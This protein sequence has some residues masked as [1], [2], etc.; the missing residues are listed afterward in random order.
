MD[1]EPAFALLCLVKQGTF[2]SSSW[3]NCK[4]PTLTGRAPCYPP[5]LYL[6]CFVSR[7]VLL[8]S[9]VSLLIWKVP[10]IAL[11]SE[12]QL[13]DNPV[14]FLPFLLSYPGCLLP[15]PTIFIVLFPLLFL[16]WKNLDRFSG[17]KKPSDSINVK[18]CFSAG[19][20]FFFLL[21]LAWN[22]VYWGKRGLQ[23]K[24]AIE[25]YRVRARYVRHGTAN[26]L[27]V[28]KTAGLVFQVHCTKSFL[29]TAHMD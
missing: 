29:T 23:S 3:R 13:I 28:T 2:A 17:K 4:L 20:F 14:G 10:R 16:V 1:W 18:T 27:L 5:P 24:S 22:K 25:V 11:A 15:F 6:F 7:D 19:S 9:H 12:L 21:F 8:Q 26:G